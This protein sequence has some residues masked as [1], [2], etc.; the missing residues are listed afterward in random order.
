MDK[1]ETDN[2]KE[3]LIKI[4][5]FIGLGIFGYFI[6]YNIYKACTWEIRSFFIASSSEIGDFFNIIFRG[7]RTFT[8]TEMPKMSWRIFF[9]CTACYLVIYSSFKFISLIDEFEEKFKV[10][11]NILGYNKKNNQIAA[12]ILADYSSYEDFKTRFK[13]FNK[14]S[15]RAKKEMKK[16]FEVE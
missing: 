7:E 1:E 10:N 15:E 5:I 2:K 16:L 4:V 3:L 14:L 8:T 6:A 9:F 13:D 12:Q 11:L